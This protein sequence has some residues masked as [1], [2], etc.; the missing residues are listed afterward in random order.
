MGWLGSKF[1]PSHQTTCFNRCDVLL[2]S[3]A[4]VPAKGKTQISTNY[5]FTNYRFWSF[6]QVDADVAVRLCE[7]AFQ[8]EMHS[9]R[10]LL[11]VLLLLP[12]PLPLPLLLLQQQQQLLLL[13]YFY[14]TTLTTTTTTTTTTTNHNH[15]NDNNNDNND[16]WWAWTPTPRTTTSAQRCTW[17]P[18][19]ATPR[20]GLLLCSC[21]EIMQ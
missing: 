1:C 5:P 4:T 21:N 8:N 2:V 10:L 15:N 16:R 13:L 9:L 12:L 17:G 18:A 3:I 14:Y 7:A 20:W 11:E 19:R 6:Q